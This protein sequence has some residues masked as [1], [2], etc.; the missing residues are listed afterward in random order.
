MF[1]GILIHFL[2]TP[3][4]YGAKKHVSYLLKC[5]ERGALELQLTQIKFLP[6]TWSYECFTNK[7]F[8]H[9]LTSLFLEASL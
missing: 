6:P 8:I 9:K 2:Y 7:K 1:I 5:N 4:V 3:L